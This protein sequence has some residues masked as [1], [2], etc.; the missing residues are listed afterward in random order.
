LEE[1]RLSPPR[2]QG[3][4]GA[5][6]K[7]ALNSHSGGE[8]HAGG[9]TAFQK[10]RRQWASPN[11][12]ASISVPKGESM[13]KILTSTMVFTLALTFGVGSVMAADQKKDRKRDGSCQSS[14]TTE[15][16][17]PSLAK[18][19]KRD[20]KRDGTCQVITPVE[21]DSMTLAADQKK[22]RKRDGSCRS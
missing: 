3:F 21:N 11:L 17:T 6:C 4:S 2:K 9:K 8:W 5:Q 10:G 18:I 22:D 7:E 12:A 13:K 16:N 14:I 19:Q 20:K 15:T 1:S